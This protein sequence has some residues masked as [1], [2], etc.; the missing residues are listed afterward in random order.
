MI[1]IQLAFCVK[2]SYAQ[3]VPKRASQIHKQTILQHKSGKRSFHLQRYT[4]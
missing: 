4:Y 3:H 1:N 2:R